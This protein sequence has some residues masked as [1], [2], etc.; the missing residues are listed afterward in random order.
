VVMDGV[1]SKVVTD[2]SA[3]PFGPPGMVE[4]SFRE[5]ELETVPGSSR[6]LLCAKTARASVCF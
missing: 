3:D 4:S 5:L 6:P 1:S 2:Y